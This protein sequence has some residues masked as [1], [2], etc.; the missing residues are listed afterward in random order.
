VVGIL[1]ISEV[2]VFYGVRN[3]VAPTRIFQSVATGFLGKRAFEGGTQ[4]AILG[5]AL[6]FTISL[7]VVT[8][9]HFASRRLA[10][11]RIHPIACGALYG[12]CVFGVMYFIVM[13]LSAA[14]P[15][16]FATPIIL[17]N[18]LFAHLFCVGIPTGLLA[19]A[20]SSSR[21]AGTTRR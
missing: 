1:D 2:V 13:P 18:A 12:L 20:T 19:R 15:P 17:A 21:S 11:L 6:H 3:G 4:T 5:L 14:G 16:K 10:M 8:I 7:I 9:Y